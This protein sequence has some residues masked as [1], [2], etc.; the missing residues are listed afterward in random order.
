MSSGKIAVAMVS[1]TRGRRARGCRRMSGANCVSRSIGP[2]AIFIR[3][4]V[5]VEN[6]LARN[7][8]TIKTGD[9]DLRFFLLVPG[10]RE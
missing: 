10:R 8:M 6:N 4:D 9:E 3:R 1:Q 5:D 7:G 2:G